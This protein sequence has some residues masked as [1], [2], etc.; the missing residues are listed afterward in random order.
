MN[1]YKE[2]N[3]QN[4]HNNNNPPK[5]PTRKEIL[6]M[7]NPLSSGKSNRNDRSGRFDSGPVKQINTINVYSIIRRREMQNANLCKTVMA[8]LTLVI[9]LFG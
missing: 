1:I 5:L 9:L 6:F 3:H 2:I 4:H 7:Q 8:A